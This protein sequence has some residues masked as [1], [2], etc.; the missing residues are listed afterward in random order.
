[1]SAYFT[2]ATF[3]NQRV[4][5]SDDAIIRKAAL[6]DGIL[7]GCEFSYSGSTLTMTAGHLLACGRHF[8][9]AA[10]QNWAVADAT[11]GYARLLLTLD[12]TRS[13][14][15]DAFDQVVDSI[16][17]AS[18]LDGFPALTQADINE[19]GTVYQVVACVVSLG[20]GGITGIVD[21]LGTSGSD[22]GDGPL[23]LV[24]GRDYGY[25]SERPSSSAEGQVFFRIEE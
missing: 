9:H 6:Q 10:A 15:K 16:E 1:M 5:P 23:V 11:S 18:A 25:E 21:Q 24:R 22:S 8:R 4:A 12:L 19:S 7:S 13:A 14:T 2:G 17:Y 20:I 3:T